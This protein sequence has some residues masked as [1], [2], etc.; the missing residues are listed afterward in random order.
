MPEQS[1]PFTERRWLPP[2]GRQGC[3]ECVMGVDPPP[4]PAAG[5]G[6]ADLTLRIAA[7]RGKQGPSSPSP[8]ASRTSSMRGCATAVPS[9]PSALS[10]VNFNALAPPRLRPR[11][12]AITP[13]APHTAAP[14]EPQAQRVVDIN[15]LRA[16]APLPRA[17][18]PRPSGPP[19]PHAAAPLEPQ[20]Q[21]TL[22]SGRA[23]RARPAVSGDARRAHRRQAANGR[24]MDRPDSTHDAARRRHDT[25]LRASEEPIR[26]RRRARGPRHQHHRAARNSA[27]FTRSICYDVASSRSPTQGKATVERRRRRVVDDVSAHAQPVRIQICVADPHLQ[28][29]NERERRT[30]R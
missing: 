24:Q 21:R 22:A 13:P 12:Q 23:D 10:V 15:A 20:A 30:W 8:A 7:R 28:I 4:A 26:A 2:H 1:R 16:L 14:L 19:G 29:P 27:A 6:A 17:P 9:S 18:V 3:D 5:R 25:V 11:P